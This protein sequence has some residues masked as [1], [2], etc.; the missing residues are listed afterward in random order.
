MPPQL[1]QEE[2][3]IT[4]ARK[5]NGG[6]SSLK[7]LVFQSCLILCDPMDWSLPGSFIRG[8]LQARI[9]EW[10]PISSSRGYSWPSNQPGSPALQ[11]DSLPPESPGKLTN[12]PREWEIRKNI[13]SLAYEA[14]FGR[15][16]CSVQLLSH[17]WLFVTPWTAGR[18]ASSFIINSRSLLR[19]MSIELVIPSNRL[20]LCNPL[21]L[22]PSI[23]PSIRVFKWV[24]SLHQ[25]SKV[26][27]F[28]LEHQSFQWIF[29]TDFL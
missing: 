21:L 10:V 8:I 29:R 4:S 7:V 28:Q 20:I 24:S 15:F 13:Q 12:S 14:A 17:F 9:L 16:N 23:F 11:A 5:P 19:H 6:T 3:S 2:G 18:E 27:E 26:L 22:L 1:C 25:V